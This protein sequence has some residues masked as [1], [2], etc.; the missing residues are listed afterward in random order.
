MMDEEASTRAV[1]QTHGEVKE[2]RHRER[3]KTHWREK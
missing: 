3:N 1:L 2:I